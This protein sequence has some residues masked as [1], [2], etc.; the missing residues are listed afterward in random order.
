MCCTLIAYYR[1]AKGI[2]LVY[3]VTNEQSFRH[4]KVWME[5]IEKVADPGVSIILVGNKCDSEKRVCVIITSQNIVL[6]ILIYLQV[7]SFEKGEELSEKY[8]V[9]FIETSAKNDIN[10]AKAFTL[11]AKEAKRHTGSNPIT[12]PPTQVTE[13]TGLAP[14]HPEESGCC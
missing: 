14:T 1:G 6:E 8:N 3:D 13:V 12:A 5:N 10:I 7:I 2:L 4:V 9:K 11:L